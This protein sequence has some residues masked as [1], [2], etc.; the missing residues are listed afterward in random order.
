M[1]LFPNLPPLPP[2][3]EPLEVIGERVFRAYISPF[4]FQET[5]G[6][7]RPLT[8]LEMSAL[9]AWHRQNEF[10]NSTNKQQR[11]QQILDTL[12]RN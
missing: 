6:T 5:D 7:V 12:G 10:N 11:R 4:S 9:L 3:T 1:V 8:N 2:L